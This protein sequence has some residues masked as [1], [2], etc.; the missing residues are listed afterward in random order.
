MRGTVASLSGHNR[1]LELDP[2]G[3]LFADGELV[4]TLR[5]TAV[6]QSSPCTLT[7][8]PPPPATGPLVLGFGEAAERQAWQRALH[9]SSVSA[10]PQ[11]IPALDRV[12]T[13]RSMAPSTPRVY[14]VIVVADDGTLLWALRTLTELG[15]T[16]VAEHFPDA[17]ISDVVAAAASAAATGA[18]PSDK[19]E[20]CYRRARGSAE[21]LRKH[22][23]L[24]APRSAA[25]REL[26]DSTP[27]VFNVL[28]PEDC[29][30]W[31]VAV[32]CA[33]RST[34]IVL[35]SH[36]A[37]AALA[38][39]ALEVAADVAGWR[40]ATAEEE[41]TEPP[42]PPESSQQG[43]GGTEV[44]AAPVAVS[45]A[46]AS[47]YAATPELVAWANGEPAAATP[48]LRHRRHRAAAP[49]SLPAA[50]LSFALGP[51]TRATSASPFFQAWYHALCGC[52][53]V[54]LL[55][56][57]PDDAVAEARARTSLSCVAL[58]L[59]ALLRPLQPF[60]L[61][62]AVHVNRPPA[63]LRM[64]LRSPFGFVLAAMTRDDWDTTKRLEPA[65]DE[66]VD[67][68]L[69]LSAEL[70]EP[71]RVY[72]RCP[73]LPFLPGMGRFLGPM[74]ELFE[75]GSI[76]GGE[77]AGG[78]EEAEGAE[79]VLEE[80]AAAFAERD[81]A[82]RCVGALGDELSALLQ[83]ARRRQPDEPGQLPPREY[84]RPPPAGQQG[85]RWRD[86]WGKRIA[87]GLRAARGE[88]AAPPA[89]AHPP[90]TP[91]PLPQRP[92]KADDVEA[93]LA[94]L[95]NT[96]S[97]AMLSRAYM[98]SSE[99]EAA[100]A[101]AAHVDAAA[102]VALRTSAAEEAL[103]AQ[104]KA[105]R[106]QIAERLSALEGSAVAAI[107]RAAAGNSHR[108]YTNVSGK[109]INIRADAAFPGVRT[110]YAVHA[111]ATVAI[112]ERRAAVAVLGCEVCFLKLASGH[113]WV[114]DVF[115]ED[116]RVVMEERGGGD[117]VRVGGVVESLRATACAVPCTVD[118]QGGGGGGGGAA[119]TSSGAASDE[120]SAALRQLFDQLAAAV[121]APPA[122]TPGATVVAAE[123]GGEL[124]SG[125]EASGDGAPLT[126]VR[127]E[128]VAPRAEE[129]VAVC[130]GGAST[131]AAVAASSAAAATASAA[132]P[133]AAA[134]AAV[135]REGGVEEDEDSQSA[136]WME[137]SA[138]DEESV[139]ESNTW[140]ELVVT[141]AQAAASLAAGDEF[142]LEEGA[143][144]YENVSTGE[145]AWT[146]P[147][148]AVIADASNVA[149][150][151][152][153]EAEDSGGALDGDALRVAGGE[154]GGCDEEDEAAEEEGYAELLGS[155]SE[156]SDDDLAPIGAIF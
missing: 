145:T 9:A 1:A 21:A 101:D 15:S 67:V 60:D 85:G 83:E 59:L 108:Y 20:K 69:D 126:P 22:V 148:D 105:I 65:M 49:D 89:D 43:G 107:R 46:H 68:V 7:L 38:D 51:T 104:L 5:G 80:S 26:H 53:V 120:D 125:D 112:S 127:E 97:Q 37:F 92:S 90:A 153:F 40:A 102:A 77:G 137:E 27:F 6:L 25:P 155:S 129:K 71:L 64:A 139:D 114:F 140:V 47:T 57:A 70:G 34:V 117:L 19:A 132:A 151:W 99:A 2:G 133:S 118:P 106:I 124:V 45:S 29:T 144:Y 72:E 58:T 115:A 44:A 88:A 113:G 109:S 56:H 135:P 93:A 122:P 150:R 98:D 62:A 154:E 103:R 48:P 94:P 116:A 16:A 50:M 54:L 95:L 30:L 131:A 130:A 75:L 149:Y 146:Q 152:W 61:P 111:G 84:D 3:A 11:R 147:P 91:P 123:V 8:A 128:P 42:K 14:D 76:A 100:C 33:L 134:A 78:G 10:L 141:K 18:P 63:V 39:L 143:L 81:V 4:C 31:G 74:L 156:S 79:L 87:S 35:S 86:R 66:E 17:A 23:L 119:T 142:P 138:T 55:G 110:T 82:Q 52:R 136:M 24:Y 41:E 73:Q 32:R 13:D 28:G 121:V 12:P 96:L 36:P